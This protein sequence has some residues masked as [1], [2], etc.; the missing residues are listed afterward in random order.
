MMF[1][2]FLEGIGNTVSEFVEDPIG[3]TVEVATQPIRDGLEIID[4]LT[5]GE[6]RYKATLRLGADVVSGMA[7]G[8]IVSWYQA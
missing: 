7:L 3:K 5:E 1:N 6:L 2:N 8:E 4:G